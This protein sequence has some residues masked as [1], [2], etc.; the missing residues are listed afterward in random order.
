MNQKMKKKIKHYLH[1]IATALPAGYPNKKLLLRT[2][3]Q[4]IDDFLEEYPNADWEDVIEHFGASCDTAQSYIEEFSDTELVASY[5]T[6]H[7]HLFLTTVIC[8]SALIALIISIYYFYSW[9]KNDALIVTETLT[10]Y[11]GT[12]MWDEWESE[13]ATEDEDAG[14]YYEVTK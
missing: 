10:V 9:W 13:W 1:E 5:K 3:Q 2:L 6:H 4:N 8:C 14:A 11:D 12:E 7:R